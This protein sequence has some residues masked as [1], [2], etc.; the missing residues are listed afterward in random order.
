MKATVKF[1]TR[2]AQ[3]LHASLLEHH[4]QMLASGETARQLTDSRRR[5]WRSTFLAFV[6]PS[7]IISALITGVLM[8]FGA[9]LEQ[10]VSVGGVGV[11]TTLVGFVILYPRA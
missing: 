10:V 6:A 5:F 1:E 11:L 2:N 3:R 9:G 4:A 7:A 8:Y